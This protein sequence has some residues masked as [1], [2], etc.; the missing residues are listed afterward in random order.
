M[1]S[2]ADIAYFAEFD[3]IF[4]IAYPGTMGRPPLNVKMT[5]VRLPEETRERIRALVGDS[6]M[7][8]FIREAVERELR[9]RER[10]KD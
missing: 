5:A 10:Q 8:Q 3:K 2:I 9:R 1:P 4:D 6:G 7:A